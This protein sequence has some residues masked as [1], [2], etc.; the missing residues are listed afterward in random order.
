MGIAMMGFT[1][2]YFDSTQPL[3]AQSLMGI[4]N[5]YDAK[6]SAIHLLGKPAVG[7]LKHPFQAAGMFGASAFSVYV[8]SFIRLL[9]T[10]SV[11][12]AAGPQTD[13]EAIAKAEKKIGK[14]SNHTMSWKESFQMFLGSCSVRPL[15]I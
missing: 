12:L 3:L 14:K 4:K 11:A 6:P 1:H 9:L 15:C 10:S 2:F 13:A 8:I 7:D 5:I